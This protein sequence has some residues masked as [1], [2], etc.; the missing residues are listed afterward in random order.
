[1]QEKVRTWGSAHLIVAPFRK[2][3]VKKFDMGG[4]IPP[5]QKLFP[6]HYGREPQLNGHSH[7]FGPMDIC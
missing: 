1:M 6:P 3:G 2:E 5:D 4:Y 7:R